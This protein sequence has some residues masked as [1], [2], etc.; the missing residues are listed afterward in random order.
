MTHPASSADADNG[1][2]DSAQAWI[3]EMGET[4]DDS[5][6]HVL[7]PVLMGLIR[8]TRARNALDVG[9][10]EGR[11]CRMLS[12]I[13]MDA[14]GIDPTARLLERARTLDPDGHYVDGIAERLPFDDAA[15]DLVISC[16]TLL[17]IPDSDA[18]IA[19]MARVL[20]PG[21]HLVTANLSGFMTANHRTARNG[22]GW[23]K[24]AD[25][26]LM[27]LGVDDY[28][29]DRAT[30]AAWRGIRVRNWHRPLSRYMQAFLSAGLILRHFDEPPHPGTGPRAEK[31]NRAPYFTVMVWQKPEAD[32]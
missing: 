14:T 30:W 22:T 4:G 11:L 12:D 23:V 17:D 28:L 26:A 2:A 18:A 7:D 3:A 24:D 5:R 8:E 6:Q 25:G 15:F 10:G 29:T 19:E 16:L 9:C 32:R 13:G 21:G 31:F 27:H 20:R 1:W